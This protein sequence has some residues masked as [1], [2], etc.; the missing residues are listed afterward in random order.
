MKFIAL[1]LFKL[2]G[3]SLSGLVGQIVFIWHALIGQIV[4]TISV[5]KYKDQKYMYI[6]TNLVK[7]HVLLFFIF[8][9]GGSMLDCDKEID[10]HQT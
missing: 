9:D 8:L 7:I 10:C 2:I 4:N 5:P 3:C 1:N 6:I